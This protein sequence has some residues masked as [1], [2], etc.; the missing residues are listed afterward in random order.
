MSSKLKVLV[1]VNVLSANQF[2]N[3]RYRKNL[4]QV[5]FS[6][7]CID[8][9][10]LFHFGS[11]KSLRTLC[12]MIPIQL[13]HFRTELSVDRVRLRIKY[14]FARNFIFIVR[15]YC[16]FISVLCVQVWRDSKCVTTAIF[17]WLPMMRFIERILRFIWFI[18]YFSPWVSRIVTVCVI[19]IPITLMCNAG[20]IP[21]N[22]SNSLRDKAMSWVTGYFFSGSI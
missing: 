6:A 7:I 19:E 18:A 16:Q 11:R 14:H 17:I 1:R 3:R 8:F 5:K 4:S 13:T 9:V 21:L 10:E 2:R 20:L 22:N 12:L 15:L